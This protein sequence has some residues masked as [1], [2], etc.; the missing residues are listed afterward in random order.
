MSDW[1]WSIVSSLHQWSDIESSGKTLFSAV[2]LS[3]ILYELTQIKRSYALIKVGGTEQFSMQHL[4]SL[5]EMLVL[6]PDI[7]KREC[8]E[9]DFLIGMLSDQRLVYHNAG[10]IPYSVFHAVLCCHIAW[11]CEVANFSY[12]YPK[13]SQYI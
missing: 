9:Y 13:L 4:T 8:N 3:M 5:L 2:V 10:G 7:V 11:L 1:L 12:L 6:K